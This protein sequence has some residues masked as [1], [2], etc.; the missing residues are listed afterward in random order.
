MG[1]WYGFGT[2]L[3]LNGFVN[4]TRLNRRLLSSLL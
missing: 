3:R 1:F 4:Q 2:G